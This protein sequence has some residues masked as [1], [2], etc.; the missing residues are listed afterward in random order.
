QEKAALNLFDRNPF[1]PAKVSRVEML[2]KSVLRIVFHLEGNAIITGPGEH[3]SL[4]AKV[5]GRTI[6]RNYT[7]ITTRSNME[8]GSV[9]LVIRLV[10]NGAMSSILQSSVTND[11]T[12]ELPAFQIS[13]CLESFDYQPNK[14]AFILMAASGTGITPMIN[15]ARYILKNPAEKTRIHL[16]FSVRNTDDIFLES[17]LKDL[18]QQTVSPS[19]FSYEVKHFLG[20]EIITAESIHGFTS[21][22]TSA[23][24]LLSGPDRFMRPLEASLVKLDKSVQVSSFGVSDR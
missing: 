14:H 8:A 1:M 15:I 5:N 4:R 20:G 13:H 17:I 10:P 7:P 9:E 18:V 3:I 24:I 23:R 19:R 2:N 22:E 11:T 6:T 21:K 16:I 12:K